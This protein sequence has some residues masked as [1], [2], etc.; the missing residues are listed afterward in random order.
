MTAHLPLPFRK[1]G[2]KLPALL[3]CGAASALIAADAPTGGEPGVRAFVLGNIYLVNGGPADSCPSEDEGGLDR[4]YAMLSS[5]DQAR[6]AGKEKRQA[7]ER[8]MNEQFGFRRIFLRGESA[9]DVKFPPGYDPAKTPTPEQAIAIG[10]LN[11]LP[12]G[13]GRLAF[14]NREVVYSACSNPYD[15]PALA[16]K[17][18]TYEG[19]VAAGMNLDGKVGRHDFAGPDGEKGVDN[20][21]WRAVG[22]VRPFREGSDPAIAHKVQLSARAPTLIELRGVDDLNN[23]PDVTVTVYAANDALTRDAR[24]GVLAGATFT[25]DPDPRLTA[26]T[27]GRI[28]NGV[29]TTDAFDV[30]VNYKEQ[31]IDAPRD[32]RAARIRARLTPDGGIEGAFFG[33][34]TLDS[35]YASIEQFTMNGAN[36]S[37]VSCPG[38]RLAIDRL[39]DGYRDPN[40][41]RNSAISSA[42]GFYGVRAFVAPRQQVAQTEQ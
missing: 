14:Q 41:G 31:I 26:T 18:R 35:F 20:Q 6:F 2:R 40:T 38:V 5:A 21:L 25:V 16:K 12:K 19:P 29:L 7:L 23:D 1:S 42:Y 15:F 34:Y 22:C 39:A 17:F 36:L 32:I 28:T 3:L 13:T 11:G 24:G 4:Y 37:G 8:H 30:R 10:A 33:Y 27:R 9:A